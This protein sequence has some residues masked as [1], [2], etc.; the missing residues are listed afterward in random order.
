MTALLSIPARLC[1]LT[2]F[3]IAGI[4][5]RTQFDVSEA[6]LGFPSVATTLW[7][8]SGYFTILTNLAVALMMAG[9]AT[10]FPPG[11]RLAGALTLAIVMVGVVYHLILAQLWA[12]VGMAWWADQ[13][14]HTAVPVL[15]FL[16]WLAFAPKSV[17]VTDLPY[18]LI[19]P[20][21]YAGYAVIR[22]TATGF[23]AY[24]FVDVGSLGWPAVALNV[25]VLVAGFA[26][27]GLGLITIARRLA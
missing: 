26:G 25:V 15:T 23:W 9:A 8:M 27:L 11:A 10:R 19:W 2:I 17:G 4:S 16:W 14:L 12:P 21:G 7:L 24:P 5:L 6:V 1:A 22:G 18:W 13:G 20:T 3:V